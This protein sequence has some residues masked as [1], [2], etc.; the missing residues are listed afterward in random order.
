MVGEREKEKEGGGESEEEKRREE[1]LKESDGLVEEFVSCVCDLVWFGKEVQREES[2]VREFQRGNERKFYKGWFVSLCRAYSEG[3]SVERIRGHFSSLL[4]FTTR[5]TKK[6]EGVVASHSF[7]RILFLFRS[8]SSFLPPL[9]ACRSS[10]APAE[11]L[12]YVVPFS[13]VAGLLWRVSECVSSPSSR[14]T[15]SQLSSVLYHLVI[16]GLGG[17]KVVNEWS[18]GRRERGGGG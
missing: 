12:S 15:L 11:A 8:G 7:P 4:S 10:S 13:L 6:A 2:R 3:V 14:E 18:R 5:Q 16:A 1:M 9:P 17:V